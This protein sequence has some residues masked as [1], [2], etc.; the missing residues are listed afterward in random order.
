MIQRRRVVHMVRF[1]TGL[2]L[3][4]DHYGDIDVSMTLI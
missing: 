4:D 1:G 3:L 2:C